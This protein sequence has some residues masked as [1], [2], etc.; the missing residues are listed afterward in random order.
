MKATLRALRC[1]LCA[2]AITLASC[3]Q[4]PT[5]GTQT[6]GLDDATRARVTALVH[7]IVE[8]GHA[9]GVV[10][11]I[12]CDG[13]PWLAMAAGKA[14]L[15][16]HR[17]MRQDDLF[18]IYSMSKPI[19]SVAVLMLADDGRLSIDDPVSKYLPEFADAKVYVSE[20]AGTM[21]TEPLRRALTVRDLLR[22]SAGIPYLAP[23]PHPVLRRYVERGIDN[24]SGERIVPTDGSAAVAT[25]AELS[26]RIAAVPLLHQPGE[27]FTY[28]G[29]TD[30]LGRLVEAVSGQRLGDFLEARLFRRLGMVDTSFQVSPTATARLTAAYASPSVRQGNGAILN[31]QPVGDLAPSKLNLVDDPQASVFSTPRPIQFGGAGLIS[32]AADFQRFSALLLGRGAVG[33][34][35]LVRAQTV[36]EMTRNQ[37]EAHARETSA[38]GSQGLGFGLGVA[39]VLRPERKVTVVPQGGLFWG[40]AAS[41]YFWV[42]PRRR[43]TGVLMTQVFGGD[44]SPYFAELMDTVYGVTVK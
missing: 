7:R 37:L 41:T 15:A 33:A 9:P 31:V 16:R 17:P 5:A 24:G 3:A 18:R 44:V 8:R 43:I 21:K 26:R 40:G 32:T 11:D 14:D 19:T 12:R 38:L 28:G 42:D 13:Q 30:V 20:E 4:V 6:C 25:V 34:Q 22:H 10:T 27:R 2:L 1:V 29:A 39:V 35:T 23:L 36:A